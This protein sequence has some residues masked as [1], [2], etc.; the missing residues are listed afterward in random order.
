MIKS[1]AYPNDVTAI[2]RWV[3]NV[4]ENLSIGLWYLQQP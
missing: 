3:V 1:Q 4:G 2:Q